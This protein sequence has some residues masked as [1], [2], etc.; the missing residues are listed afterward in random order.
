MRNLAG[1]AATILALMITVPV[2]AQVHSHDH[3]SP[4]SD[5]LARDIKALSAEE[6]DGLR[7]GEGVGMALAAELNGYPGPRHVLEMATMLGLSPDQRSSIQSIFEEMEEE[8]QA[9]GKKIVD[10][11]RD[12]DRAFAEGTIAEGGLEELAGEIGAFRAHLRVAHLRAHLRLLPLLTDSQLREY[13]M[14]R[15]YRR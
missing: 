3:A 12:L 10:L 2:Q 4:C 7:K 13:A 6:V 8:A 14:L 15:G 5:F 1:T 11:E 9:L